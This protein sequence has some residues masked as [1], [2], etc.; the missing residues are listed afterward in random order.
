[1]AIQMRRGFY[2]DFDPSKML[3]GEWAVSIDSDTNKQIVW[4][5]F[6]PGVTKRMGTYEDFRQQIQ[7]AT[8]EIK[9]EYISEFHAI[10]DQIELLAEQT[11]ENTTTVIQ[12]RD[13]TVNTYLPQMLKYLNGTKNNASLAQASQADAVASAAQAATYADN[14]ALSERYADSHASDA[15]TSAA[16]AAESATKAAMSAVNAKDSETAAATSASTATTKATV[17]SNSASAAATSEKNAKTS[18]T[19]AAS[20]KNAAA[21]SASTA[22]SKAT[23]AANSAI[24]SESY[25]V[26]AQEYAEEWK[27]SLLP[28]GT[29]SFF[30]LPRE[31]NV[32]G[33]MYN[34]NGAF[35]TDSRFK[36]GAG[37]SYPA[38]T[39]VY[40]TADGYWD[41]L[42][43]TFA[44]EVTQAEY[45]TFSEAKKMNGTI[46]FI[47]DAN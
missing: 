27:G 7:E 6:A 23:D 39:N 20:S 36:D 32:A 22:T 11:N 33:H 9:E 44:M 26:K 42:S 10:L 15:I 1:M 12:I 38:G 5:C 2:A 21:N 17:A 37:Y 40:W 3:P 19:N 24:L 30:Q 29:I 16:A 14:A 13:D 4:M 25:A 31:N 34:I 8:Q 43:G 46:Y 45:D 41:C 47:T 35:I 28:K 18:E